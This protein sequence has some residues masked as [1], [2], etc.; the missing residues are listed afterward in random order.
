M[1]SKVAAC[2]TQATCSVTRIVTGILSTVW[3]NAQWTH[4]RDV[5]SVTLALT[6]IATAC[7]APTT[8]TTHI[9]TA[10][11]FALGRLIVR[12]SGGNVYE[13]S[14]ERGRNFR[15]LAGPNSRIVS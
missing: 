14:V 1:V 8:S 3:L 2:N 9:S 13:L 5:W 4:R 6:L 15:R 12:D 11:P 7:R 10:V